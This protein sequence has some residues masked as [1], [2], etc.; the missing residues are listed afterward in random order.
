ME[1]NEFDALMDR[2]DEIQS[3]AMEQAEN[4]RGPSGEP[5]SKS[6]YFLGKDVGVARVKSVLR[7]RIEVED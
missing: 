5:T 4:E 1:R 3:D 7:E 6:M 2:V